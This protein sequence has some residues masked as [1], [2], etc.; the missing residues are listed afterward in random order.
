MKWYPLEARK[1]TLIRKRMK[2]PNYWHDR[3]FQSP[4][5][6]SNSAHKC[7]RVD[8]DSDT[9]QYTDYVWRKIGSTN[10]SFLLHPHIF[11]VAA[12]VGSTDFGSE[13]GGWNDDFLRLNKETSEKGDESEDAFIGSYYSNLSR[14]K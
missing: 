12:A 5:F 8:K 6:L 1:A 3:A 11:S 4:Y 2:T 9:P 14:E 13:N 7:I 10:Q